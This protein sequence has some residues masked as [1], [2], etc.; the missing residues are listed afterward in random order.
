M[1]S[2]QKSTKH[3]LPTFQSTATQ[4]NFLNSGEQ[5]LSDILVKLEN[6]Q[7]EQKRQAEMM[8]NKFAA[9]DRQIKLIR[10]EFN[11]VTDELITRSGFVQQTYFEWEPVKNQEDLDNLECRLAEPEFKKNFSK[12]LDNQLS[13]EGSDDRLHD[14]MDIF[15]N[16]EFV[17]KLSWTGIGRP[18]AKICFKKYVNV[19][20][21]FKEL[22]TFGGVTPTNQKLKDLFQNKFKHGHQT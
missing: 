19:I 21:Q 22:G 16:R 15:F 4:T 17:T 12:Y 1:P 8:N 7:E 6:I 5:M 3:F 14:A 9:M 18:N 2:C 20:N 11:I 10:S 13:T